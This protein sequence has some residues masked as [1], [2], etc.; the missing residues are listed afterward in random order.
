[1][2][3]PADGGAIGAVGN[4]S[5]LEDAGGGAAGDGGG[6]FGDSAAKAVPQFEQYS[7]PGIAGVP[8]VGQ[9]IALLLAGMVGS[10]GAA[11]FDAGSGLPQLSQNAAPS[12]LSIW[13][14]G[15]RIIQTP[16]YSF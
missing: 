11:A 15:H 14:F 16:P 3:G 9:M 8:H 10:N 6:A 12:T 1:M 7:S 5:G 2:V 4:E 13:Q